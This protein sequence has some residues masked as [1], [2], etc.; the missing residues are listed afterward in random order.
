[1]TKKK[2]KLESEEEKILDMLKEE[3]E[4]SPGKLAYKIN[5][6][7]MKLVEKLSIMEIKGLLKLQGS[8]CKLC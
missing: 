2:K 4:I 1:M 8:K 6:D 5:I 7:Q 3:G